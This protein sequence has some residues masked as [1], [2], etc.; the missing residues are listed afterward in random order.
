[1]ADNFQKQQKTKKEDHQASTGARSREWGMALGDSSDGLPSGWDNL[2]Q[3]ARHTNHAGPQP[4]PRTP[5][6][7]VIDHLMR[8]LHP[9]ALTEVIERQPTAQA[10]TAPLLTG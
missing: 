10:P 8:G 5:Y 9:S 2:A 6:G 3:Q 1:M 7:N 4:Q